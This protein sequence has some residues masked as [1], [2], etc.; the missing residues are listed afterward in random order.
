MRNVTIVYALAFAACA[1]PGMNGDGGDIDGG[2]PFDAGPERDGGSFDP[3]GGMTSS[4]AGS[5]GDDG[6][7]MMVMDAGMTDAGMAAMDAGMMVMTDAG[8]MATDAGMMATDGGRDAGMMMGPCAT[9]YGFAT[10]PIRWTVPR[11]VDHLADESPETSYAT[12]DLTNDGRL[13]LVF[14]DLPAPGVGETHWVVY[15]GGTS[16]F[17]TI[18]MNWTLP[19][20]VTRTAFDTATVSHSTVDLT[21]DGILD[22]VF[23]DDTPAGVGTT[24]WLVYPGGKSGF[25]AA[26]TW[27]IPRAVTDLS[28]DTATV[29]YATFDLTGDGRL[30]LVFT[31]DVMSGVGTT[32]WLVY[33]GGASGFGGAMDYTLPRAVDRLFNSSFDFSHATIDLT[34]DGVPDLVFTNDT[35]PAVGTAHW[36]VYAG[37]ASGFGAATMYTLPRAVTTISSNTATVA[38]AT[39]DLDGDGRLDLVFTDDTPPGAGTTRWLFYPGGASGFGAA[40]DWTIPRMVPD[41]SFDSFDTVWST[42]DMT[43]D[44]RPDLVFTN[45]PM[46]GVGTTEWLVY[47]SCAGGLI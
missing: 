25:G 27:S 37:G 6:G 40:I 33:P 16:G 31:D 24:H 38:H 36:L 35:P 32:R 15:P 34:A 2:A 28:F 9:D 1:D 19:R 4:D 3:D 42:L 8:M 5:G 12:I 43:W 29:R 7:M 14:T 47:P 11:A 45:D 39:F 22:L 44:D 18:A 26:T 10:T 30:D 20:P 46:P 23:T 13:D 21:G 17:S 41:L